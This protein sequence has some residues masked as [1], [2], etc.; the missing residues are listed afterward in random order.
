MKISNIF[1]ALITLLMLGATSLF[2]QQESGQIHGIITDAASGEVLIGA[3]IILKGTSLGAASDVYG[4][5]RIVGISPGSYTLVVRFIGYKGKEM[6]FEVTPG[7]NAVQNFALSVEAVEGQEV[8][9][10]AQAQGQR[11]A[12]NEQLTSNTIINVV[13]S[14]KIQKLPDASAATALSRLPGVSLMNGDEVVIRGVEAKLNQILIN[15][16]E[17]PSTDMNTRATNLGFIS[18]N[19]LSGI[20]VV[21]ALTPDMDANTIGGVVNLRLREAPA[22]FHFDVL[23]QGNYNSSDHTT[24]NYTFWASVSNRFFDDK[25]GV[26]LQGNMDRSDGGNQMAQITVT[27]LGTS[28]NTYGNGTYITNGANFEYRCRSYKEQRREPYIGLS[29]SEW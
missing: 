27:Q 8:I 28:N 23:T 10:T 19:L 26:F 4:A 9:V 25:L 13:S 11:E 18:S 2:A 12:I 21:K 15:G 17:L 29:T 20:E 7:A 1:F 5:Y 16:I 6:P 3:N 14:E 22:G 24:D